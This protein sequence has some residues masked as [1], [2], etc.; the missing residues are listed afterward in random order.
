MQFKLYYF[1]LYFYLLVCTVQLIKTKTL[2]YKLLYK[3]FNRLQTYH[4]KKFWHKNTQFLLK[5]DGYKKVFNFNLT[6]RLTK[7]QRKPPIEVSI[8]GKSMVGFEGLLVHNNF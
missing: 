8:S 7:G 6:S 1:L 5:H 2:F 4:A 3:L